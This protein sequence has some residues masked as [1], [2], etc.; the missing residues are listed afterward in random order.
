MA[1]RV[2]S[3]ST[4]QLTVFCGGEKPIPRGA[5]IAW[6]TYWFKRRALTALLS[7]KPISVSWRKAISSTRSSSSSSSMARDKNGKVSSHL[8]STS[9]AEKQVHVCLGHQ[10]LLTKAGRHL[11]PTTLKLP[12]TFPISKTV[13][14]V[15]GR[16]HV[17]P[18]V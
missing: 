18:Y 13:L 17:S 5:S 11:L 8:S 10:S 4:I 12:Q 14:A 1:L 15:H 3:S 2:P 6:D 7:G 9:A 16:S